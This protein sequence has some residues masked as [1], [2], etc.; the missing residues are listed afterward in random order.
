[1]YHLLLLLLVVIL[2]CFLLI[3]QIKFYTDNLFSIFFFH[4]LIV[5]LLLK[6]NVRTFSVLLEIS[7]IF[8]LIVSLFAIIVSKTKNILLQ[9]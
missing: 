7:N 5:K 4:F 6:Q 9:L 3:V 2:C 1:M 8:C